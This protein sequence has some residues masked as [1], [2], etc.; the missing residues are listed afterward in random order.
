MSNFWRLVFILGL[1]SIL[2]YFVFHLQ[3][4]LLYLLIAGILALIGAPLTTRLHQISF[5]GKIRLPRWVGAILTLIL[6]YLVVVGIVAL[7]VPVIYGEIDMISNLNFQS[8]TKQLE[9]SLNSAD[10]WINRFNLHDSSSA[11]SDA[12]R[13]GFT[14]LVNMGNVSGIFSSLVGLL[15]N[16]AAA[17]FS[18]AFITSFFLIDPQIPYR[19]AVAFVPAKWEFKFQHVTTT[20]QTLLRRYFIG[21]LIQITLVAIITVLGLSLVGV[22]YALLIGCFAGCIN[23]IPFIGP[24]IGS[25]FGMLV[26]ITASL[27]DPNFYGTLLPLAFKIFTVFLVVHIIDNVFFQPYIFSNSIKAHPLEIF[28][29]ILIAGT[30][31]GIVGMLLAMPC[32]TV[33]RVVAIELNK[34][35]GFIKLNTHVHKND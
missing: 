10:S 22:K 20:C 15:G 9:L 30:M 19:V 5:G 17:T 23:I 21:V 16:L 32:Y 11:V 14:N 18:I 24:L 8:I 27:D 2:A 31:A 29:V 26:G 34:E 35:F 7:V 4:I 6:F 33:I 1:L 3:T 12:I 28:L 25:I 13:D